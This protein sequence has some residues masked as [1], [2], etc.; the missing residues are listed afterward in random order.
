MDNDNGICTPRINKGPTDF[1][2]HPSPRRTVSRP[3]NDGNT[4]PQGD[5]DNGNIGSLAPSS[6]SACTPKEWAQPLEETI[7]RLGH[8]L[9]TLNSFCQGTR[10]VHRKM[11]DDMSV[12]V[13][14]FK[15]L[16]T[17]QTDLF[18]K[19]LHMSQILLG[20]KLPRELPAPLRLLT[21][22]KSRGKVKPT[23]WR[24]KSP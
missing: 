14:V 7:H 11:K 2:G 22:R 4:V 18:V 20:F 16:K 8:I 15:E 12:A 13:K 17:A 5:S 21:R 1:R 23:T 10:N 3:D 19:P 9:A 24:Y 6:E